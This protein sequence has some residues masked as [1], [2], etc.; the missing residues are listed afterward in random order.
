MNVYFPKTVI[1]IV[2]T[3]VCFMKE[4]CYV[5]TNTGYS[6]TSTYLLIAIFCLALVYSLIYMYETVPFFPETD[7]I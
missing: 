1:S 6:S 2:Y 5:L 4:R 7:Y 3:V